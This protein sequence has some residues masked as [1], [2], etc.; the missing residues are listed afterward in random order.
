MGSIDDAALLPLRIDTVLQIRTGKAKPAFGESSG[1]FKTPKTE[2]IRVNF[3]G[4][5][6]DERVYK[7]H[8]G[9][10]NAL[11]QYDSR[12]YRLWKEEIPDRAHFFEAGAFGEN[13]VTENMSEETVC[14]GDIVQLGK[15]LIA[16]VNKPRPPCYKLNHRFS[17]SYHHDADKC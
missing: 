11:M 5:E 2:P 1:I 15:E 16:Q 17:T 13:I 12:H 9:L 4:C 8:L 3:I 7:G 10:D 14:I 6:G